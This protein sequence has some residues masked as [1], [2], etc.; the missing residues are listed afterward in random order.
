MR[1]CPGRLL[2]RRRDIERF[3]DAYAQYDSRHVLPAA[4]GWLDQ[5]CHFAAAVAIA[6]DERGRIEEARNEP[7]R[8]DAILAKSKARTARL[9]GR[10]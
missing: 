9:Q 6:D 4:G 2:E 8:H 1:V 10:S 7:D 3:L 5:A